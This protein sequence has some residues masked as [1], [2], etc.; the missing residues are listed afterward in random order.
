MG[1]LFLEAKSLLEKNDQLSYINYDD[2]NQSG[3]EFL[4]SDLWDFQFTVP[5]P[6][7][8]FPGNDF[9]RRR[10]RAVT[11]T[12]NSS[13]G[14]LGAVIRGFQIWQNTYSG[15]TA[16]TITIEYQDFEDQAIMAWLD[17]WREKLGDRSN[18][19]SFRKQD[20]VAQGELTVFNSSR[21]AI[22]KYTI[23]SI[24]LQDPGASG[25][26][27]PGFNS[28]DPSDLGQISANFSFEH[29]E[30]SWENQ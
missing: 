2:L 15:T 7:V 11:P 14:Q 22:R 5:A 9:V 8:Y 26:Y 23:K 4:R 6:A 3:Y 19:F 20:T 12:F 10:M 17:D 1:N 18:R 21:V 13:I 28:E 16:G 30:L 27:S 24:Q 29:M 25:L